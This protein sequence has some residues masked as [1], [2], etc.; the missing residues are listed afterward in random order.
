VP[1]ESKLA[2]MFRPHLILIVLAALA[3]I[4]SGLAQDGEISIDSKVSPEQIKQWLQ[5]S[6]SFKVSWGAYFASKSDDV[7]NNDLYLEI[8]SRRLAL[9]IAPPNPAQVHPNPD[10]SL[11]LPAQAISQILNALIEKNQSVPASSLIPIMSTF[12]VKSLI[13][14]AIT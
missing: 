12:P 6:D 2:D 11:P 8:M 14:A 13:L 5:S 1:A 7:I 3:S 9:W 4:A 10:G